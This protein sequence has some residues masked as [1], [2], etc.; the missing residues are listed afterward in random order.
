[1]EPNT[2]HPGIKHFQIRKRKEV[3]L[4]AG[5]TKM[6]WHCLDYYLF[7]GLA[8]LNTNKHLTRLEK[9]CSHLI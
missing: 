9:H 7:Y 3:H 2:G 4:P 8:D 6:Q 5:Q 1:M